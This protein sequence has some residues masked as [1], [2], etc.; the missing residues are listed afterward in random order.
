[1][2][3]DIRTLVFCN[4]LVTACLAASLL[5][6]RASQKTYP[7]FTVWTA[8]TW[9]LAAGYLTLVARGATPLWLNILLAN[10]SF[11]LGALLRLEGIR[12]FLGRSRLPRVIYTTPVLLLI[13]LGC[14]SFIRNNAA[15]R[16]M[17]ISLFLALVC[18][19]IARVLLQ[20]GTAGRRFYRIFGG[21]HILWGLLLAA[22][23]LLLLANPQ[24]GLF[25]ATADQI[26]FF[27]AI[28]VLEF[29]I[30]FCFIMLNAGR[31]EEEL[32]HSRDS[33]KAAMRDLQQSLSEVKVLSGLLP[34]CASCKKIRDDKGSWQQIEAYIRDRSDANFTHGICPDCAQNW[35]PSSFEP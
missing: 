22:R 16:T 31:L 28:T 35:Y 3:V 21:L 7:G 20:S 12:V 2:V 13:G 34:I 27:V 8:G 9:L 25:D 26:F 6:Y 14:F 29:G 17:L 15:V 1:M 30:G 23:A 10:G 4:A 11:S 33:L 18:F 5:I 19:A 32:R 24:V